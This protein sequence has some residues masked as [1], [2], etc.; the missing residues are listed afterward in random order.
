M[1]RPK[2]AR[3]TGD[4]RPLGGGIAGPGG[5]HDRDGVVVDT[6]NAV[7]LDTSNVAMMTNPSDGRRVVAFL[8]GGK[9]NQSVQRTDV[10]FLTGADGAA[11]LCAEL[12]AIAQR[13]G[14]S[15]IDEFIDRFT[16][17]M[18]AMP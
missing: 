4:P 7:I 15:Y 9:I 16:E 5:P 6:R 18:E 12:I 3:K 8:L 2:H 11:A 10:L 17:R 13:E 14:G 1:S